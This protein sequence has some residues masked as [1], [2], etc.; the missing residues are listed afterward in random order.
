LVEE[1]YD[2]NPRLL[3]KLEKLLFDKT[4]RPDAIDED[5]NEGT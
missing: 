4:R 5:L 1:K 3:L 2:L